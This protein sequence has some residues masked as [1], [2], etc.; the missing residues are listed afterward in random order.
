MLFSNW[1]TNSY[2]HITTCIYKI[3]GAKHPNLIITEQTI[4]YRWSEHENHNFK[5]IIPQHIKWYIKDTFSVSYDVVQCKKML[6]KIYF[7]LIRNAK[8]SLT[9]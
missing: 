8:K 3:N 4:E 5:K 6:T 9:T 1:L 2:T 7:F